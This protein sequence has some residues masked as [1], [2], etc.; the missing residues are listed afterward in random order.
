MVN[1]KLSKIRSQFPVLTQLSRG[2]RY[3][4][5]D[6]AASS[7]M[8]AEV[9]EAVSKY[10]QTTHANVHRGVYQAS[11]Q[12]T[13][14]FEKARE[15]VKQFL[16]AKVNH[17]VIFTSGTTDSINLVAQC[18]G[19][20][21][22]KK[23]DV[24]LT[25]IMEHHS[26]L[27]PWQQVAKQTGARLEFI[28]LDDKGGFHYAQFEEKLKKHKPKLVAVTMMSNALGT[29]TPFEKILRAAH[30]SGALV[31]LDGA[32]GVPHLGARVAD[33]DVDFLAFSAHKMC[34]PTGVGVLCAKRE[35]LLKMTPYRFGGDMILQV[36][37]ESSTWNEL[38]Y[39][40]EAGTPNIS[41]VIGLGAAVNF[42]NRIGM[43]TIREHERH[44]TA[45]A[46]ERLNEI[47]GLTVYGIQTHGESRGGAI[48]FNLKGIHPHDVGTAVD[49]D[50]VAM[51]VGHHCAQPLMEY[52]KVP[53][54]VRMSFYLYNDEK[55]VDQAIEALKRTQEYFHGA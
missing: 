52:L 10:H 4:F 26:N 6:S 3:A 32:Q 53:A 30:A 45:Y 49:L 42:L 36:K 9:I 12:A 39:R 51:R 18:W 16:G 55:D 35:L 46:L 25:T 29:V 1:E 7:Q 23:D 2:K 8:P 33:W 21:Q 38:P 24:I 27:V 31:M 20:S 40:F 17:E 5:L 14:L 41:G 13:D 37:R 54:T 44:L 43:D 19:L 11:V 28:E 15:T 48:S 50:G 22:L 34:G 47:S